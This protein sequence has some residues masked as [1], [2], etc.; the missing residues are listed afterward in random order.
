MQVR[1][2]VD[3]G[4]G[5][6]LGVAGA[7][8]GHDAGVAGQARAAVRRRRGQ[9]VLPGADRL[10]Q[11][12]PVSADVVEE[13]AHRGRAQLPLGAGGGARRGRAGAVRGRSRERIRRGGGGGLHLRRGEHRGGHLTFRCC[14]LNTA[15]IFYCQASLLWPWGKL[16][17]FMSMI[18]RTHVAGNLF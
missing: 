1:L 7:G 12:G 11:V 15:D 14:L 8:P 9:H 10:A 16:A 4:L 18:G 2:D 17:Q 13:P 6:A 3:E 5:D